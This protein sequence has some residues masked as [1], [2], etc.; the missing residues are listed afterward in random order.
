[1]PPTARVSSG[2]GTS[3]ALTGAARAGDHSAAFARYAARRRPYAECA[4]AGA[5]EGADVVAPDSWA[6]IHARNAS[7]NAAAHADGS[8]G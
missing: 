5:D 3:L 8:P 7:F 4:W 6:A 1:M 2:R